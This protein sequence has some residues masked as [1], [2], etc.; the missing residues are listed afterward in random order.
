MNPIISISGIRGIFGLSFT[1]ENIMKYTTAFANYI[2]NKRVVIG[3][4]GRLN[5]DIVEKLIESTL[6]FNGCEVI[7]LGIAPTPTIS[8]AVETLK[9]NGGI[10]I[11]ASHNPQE[12]NG[13]KFINGKGIFFDADE[14]KEFQS[15][16]EKENVNLVS[17]DKVRQVEY[18]PGFANYHIKRVLGINLINLHK[19]RKRKF[20]VVVDCVNSSG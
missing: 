15:F 13:M 1:P 4:D 10:A 2:N 19:I 9:A 14:N 3:R 11:T 8:L 16:F 18:Y 7:N 12:W 6:L 5:G 17:W 20:K